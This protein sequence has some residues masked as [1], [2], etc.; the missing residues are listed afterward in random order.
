MIKYVKVIFSID[1]WKVWVVVKIWPCQ[2]SQHINK[3]KGKEKT[4]KIQNAIFKN[5]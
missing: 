2:N 4:D 3:E 5:Y 1:L